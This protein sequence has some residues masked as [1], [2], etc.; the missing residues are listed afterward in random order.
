MTDSAAAEQNGRMWALALLLAFGMA[1]HRD[2]PAA[3]G[4]APA[5]PAAHW[6]GTW[7]TSPQLV[8]AR[9][10]PPPPGLTGATLRQT[11]EV[12]IGGPVLRVHLSNQYGRTPMVIQAAEV[13]LPAGPG[14][15]VRASRRVLTFHGQSGITIAPGATATSDPLR[16]RLRPLS[17]LAISIEF[18]AAPADLTGHPG[19]RETSFLQPGAYAAAATL[20]DPKTAVH[21]YVITG[22]DVIDRRGPQRGYT[23]HPAGARPKARRFAA[24][25]PEAQAAAIV[26]L[27]DSIT[28]G[29]GTTTDGNNRWTDDLA[30]RLQ[31]HAGMRE[32]AV[33]NEGIGGNCILKQCL[34]PAAIARFQRDVLDQPGARWV[35]IFEGVNDIGTS[36]KSVAAALIAA[37]RQMIARA[38]A[39]HLKIYAATVTPFGGSFYD[40]PAHRADWRKLNHWIRGSEAFDGV[41]DFAAVARDPAH[42]ARLLAADDHGDHLHFNPAGYAR[43]AAA[44]PL[45]WFAGAPAGGNGEPPAAQAA[46]ESH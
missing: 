5:A 30:R 36:H 35:M 23:A 27:G 8:E 42:P 37:D 10:M 28:D 24:G 4:S 31:G 17:L 7:A 3:A 44:V 15:I 22:V 6:V 20:P 33:L 19:S 32:I 11:I 46:S 39:R 12:S 41:V 16:F 25:T 21:W 45:R 26:V 40:S 29:Y 13:A 38:H 9:N 14:A 34:G 43:L 18:G 1:P 2:R